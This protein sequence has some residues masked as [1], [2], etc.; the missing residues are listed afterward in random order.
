MEFEFEKGRQEQVVGLI[1]TQ[2][3]KRFESSAFAFRATCESLLFKLLAWVEVHCET[4]AEK[5]RLDRWRG[6]NEDTLTGINRHRQEKEDV[7]EIEDDASLPVELIENVE[8]LSRKEYRVEE[9]LDETF[10]DM[11]Q[12][13]VFLDEMEDF[14]V[15]QDDKVQTL[16]FRQHQKLVR[17][18][19]R[20]FV[21]GKNATQ[22]V[23]HFVR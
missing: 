5:R 18:S 19:K 9:I 22:F 1:R 14:S 6:Q 4:G 16:K 3:L 10:L 21:F 11:D 8:K 13:I 2:L 12:L 20:Y 7:E 23:H 15:T 17:K